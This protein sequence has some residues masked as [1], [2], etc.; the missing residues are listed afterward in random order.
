LLLRAGQVEL[1]ELGNFLQ[2]HPPSRFDRLPG[3]EGHGH[4]GVAILP[5]VESPYPAGVCGRAQSSWPTLTRSLGLR[6]VPADA[7]GLSGTCRWHLSQ[8]GRRHIPACTIPPAQ[9][10]ADLQGAVEQLPSREYAAEARPLHEELQRIQQGRRRGPQLLGDIL[11]VVLARPDH[12]SGEAGS[13]NDLRH[14]LNSF[15]NRSRTVA[16]TVRK[17]V[18]VPLE[19]VTLFPTT[20]RSRTVA[21]TVR[22][23][24]LILLEHGTLVFPY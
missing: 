15:S 5:A 1:G 7:T 18:L 2:G 9:V 3:E 11:P 14:P 20:N 17:S 22:K 13:C 21:Y 8:T 23:S 19:H 24:L 6:L 10:L 12:Q 4:V 16:Y